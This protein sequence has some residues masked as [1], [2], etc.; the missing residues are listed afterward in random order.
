MPAPRRPSD[1]HELTV[2][3]ARN[4]K[5]KRKD[6]K[7]VGVLPKDAPKH[8]DLD[9]HQAHARKEVV[10]VIP[11]GV[12]TGSDAFVARL[13]PDLRSRGRLGEQRSRQIEPPRRQLPLHAAVYASL[14]LL[15]WGLGQG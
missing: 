15:A 13:G 1:H 8:L 2:A 7:G 14:L 6:P 10:A 5:R 11:P 9:R 4:S 12:A 3:Y